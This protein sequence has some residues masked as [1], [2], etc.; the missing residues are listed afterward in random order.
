M[1]Q[2]G[3]AVIVTGRRAERG[4]SVVKDIA[5]AGG[6]ARFI[7]ADLAARDGV[8]HLVGEAGHV[9]VLVH[10]AVF[11][12]SSPTMAQELADFDR[13][14]TLNVRT[15]YALTKKLVPSMVAKGS[16]SIINVGS[17]AC[18]KAIPILSVYAGNKSALEAFTRSWAA[19]FGRSGVRVNTVSPGITDTEAAVDDLG[20]EMVTAMANA[21]LLGRAA[22]PREIAEVITFMAS[23]AASFMTGTVVHVDGGALVA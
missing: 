1:A 18:H 9:D 8:D 19:E 12:M 15:P 5:A 21:N 22:H 20:V 11:P 13:A 2:A 7:E 17:L 6:E 4:N 10:N 23:D 3:A 16:G 14:F